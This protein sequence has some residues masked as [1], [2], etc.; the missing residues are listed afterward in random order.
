[1]THDVETVVVGAGVVGLAIAAQLGTLGHDVLIL[2]KHSLFG[3]ETSSRHSEV[4]HAG[5]YYPTGSLKAQLCTRGKAMLYDYCAKHAIEHKRLG[6]IIVATNDAQVA[7]LE[8]I[9]AQAKHNGVND[10]RYLEAADIAQMEPAIS[11]KAGLLSPSTGIIDSHAF[12]LSLLGRAQEHGAMTV[13][14]THLTL[15]TIYSV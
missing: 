4:I 13:S 11:A 6:K 8:S 9:N 12:M 10:L 5:I 14:Y 1:M 7:T 2:E 15:P 3:N